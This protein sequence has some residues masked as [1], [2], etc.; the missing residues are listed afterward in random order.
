[1]KI[2]TDFVTNS[3]SSSFIFDTSWKQ[4]DIIQ[5]LNSAYVC[6]DK[7]FTDAENIL[8]IR[9]KGLYSEI[10]KYFG[11]YG[12]YALTMEYIHS[13]K[14]WDDKY[15]IEYNVDF[16]CLMQEVANKFNAKF[17]TNLSDYAVVHSYLDLNTLHYILSVSRH[18][19]SIQSI[20][21]LNTD[22]DILEWFSII[23]EMIDWYG[24]GSEVFKDVTHEQLMS[25][26]GLYDFW[27]SHISCYKDS[28]WIK[29]CKGDCDKCNL[30]DDA[31]VI[32]IK[33]I[34]YMSYNDD[35][36][37]DF[38]MLVINKFKENIGALFESGW[39]GDTDY[40]ALAIYKKYCKYY[41]NHMG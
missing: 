27:R 32:L 34:K 24:L 38:K 11:N 16:K 17:E 5:L 21:N 33:S 39:E 28:P 19:Q 3:S 22:N 8:K 35:I 12:K 20:T 4:S 18:K 23:C 25:Y 31:K 9:N 6:I 13:D 30:G 36:T 15:S 10:V 1:M 14:Y 37:D 29:D 40:I 7:L 2:R 26:T 41:C